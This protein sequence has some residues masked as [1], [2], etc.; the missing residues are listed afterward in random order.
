MGYM[1]KTEATKRAAELKA[2]MGTY[3]YQYYVLDEPTVSDAVY[4]GLMRELKALESEYPELISPDSPTQ[5]V[6]GEAL[7]GFRKVRHTT[8]M[9]SINDVFSRED[10]EAWVVRTD[11]LV[12]G[13]TTE[14]FTDIKMDG[15]A[16]ALTY[17]D[18]VLLQAV[19]RGDGQ[20]GEDVTMN[21]RTIP[22][23]PLTLR[24]DPQ[25]GRFLQGRTEIRGEIIM[26]KTDFEKLNQSRE[27]EGKPLFM[28][29]RNLAAGTI[30]QLDPKLVA[31]RPLHFRAYD[32]LRDD[33]AEI[34]TNAYAYQAIRALGVAANSQARVFKTINEVMQYV[35]EWEVKRHGLPF[36]TDGLVVKVNDRALYRELGIV[37]KNP[38]GSVAYK[39]P[40]EEAT[41][42][43]KDIVLSIGRTGAAT[44]IAVFDPTIIAG[45]QVQH[46]SLH[47][48]DEIA[49]LD[50]R[51][52]D[53]AVVYKAGDI[54]P[55][56][57]RVLTELRPKDAK[58][59][60][61]EAELKRQ[62]PE[63]TFERPE[64][65]VVYRVQG[66]TSSVLL[67]YALQHFASRGALDID[68]LGEK[69]VIAL[70]DAGLVNDLADIYAL[71]KEQVLSLD[72]FAEVSAAK[73]IDAIRDRKHPELPR[74]IYGLGIRHVGSQTAIDLAEKFESMVRLA[75]ATL[76][77]LLA[78]DG[79]GKVVAESIVAWFADPDNER[80]LKKFKNLGVVPVYES[81]ANGPLHGQ[82]FVITGGLE[83]FESRDVAADKIRAL[84]GT[85]QSSVGKDTTYLV[86]GKNVGA[87]KLAKAAKLGTR[88]ISESDLVKILE[89]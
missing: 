46:A 12:P 11:K 78:V 84:G 31:E 2:L 41:A 5:R 76:D 64:G 27:A 67:R 55:K 51:V 63:L 6:G 36:N 32:L 79:I 47:N 83:H 77:E 39:Y 81:R 50:I 54:I 10:V 61:M 52:G 88:Q 17:Q 24:S 57:D 73:L 82:S 40:A 37:G 56:V 34:P 44:P 68:T 62:Y 87:S 43:L 33:P 72:R 13:R 21:V 16:C 1:N 25:Y 15:L 70:V 14:F 65:E 3:S 59:F 49:R 80:L 29:P 28:N 60:N 75:T 9:I 30:R 4:D 19:T 20:T 89:G 86:V 7:K 48:S 71:T 22:S 35:D 58:P 74:F 26:L 53:T 18:G 45:T 8:R 85:F 42:I 38:R 23:V 69:N 66:A